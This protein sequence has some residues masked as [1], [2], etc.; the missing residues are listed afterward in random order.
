M[1]ELKFSFALSWITK[2]SLPPK[3]GP[4]FAYFFQCTIDFISSDSLNLSLW[5]N[6]KINESLDLSYKAWDENFPGY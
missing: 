5:V 2:S 1:Y 6:E 3:E 4:I